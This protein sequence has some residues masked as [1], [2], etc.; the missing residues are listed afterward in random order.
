MSV[1]D[2]VKQKTDIL[3]VIGQYATLTKAGSNF[4]ALCP[5]HSETR[6]SF[7]VYPEQQSWHC[8][9]ACSTG[10]DVFSFIMKKENMDFAEALRLL[11]E[12]AGVTIPSRAE[13]AVGQDRR[14]RLYKVNKSAADY[15]HNLLLNDRA[16]ENARRYSAYRGFSAR[17]IADFHL[18]YGP[19]N[20][21]SLKQHLTEQGY[22]QDELLE[23]G[24]IVKSDG[25][26]THD[27]F[28]NRL[29]FPISDNRE[30]VIGFGAR[31]LDD[32]M[33]KYLNSPQTPVFDKSGTLYAI[34]R[35]TAAI[36]EQNRVVIVEGYMDVIT[37]HQNGF[38]NVVAAMGTAITERQLLILK[39]LSEN[40]VLALDADSAGESAML[41][42]VGYENA[43]NTEVKVVVLPSGKDPDDVIKEDTGTW[44]RLLGEAL[45]VIDYTLNMI[46]ARLDM[47]TARSKSRAVEQLMPIIAE[48]KD[49]TRQDHYLTRLSRLTG[50]GY[51]SLEITLRNLVMAQ[52]SGRP[53]SRE[54]NIQISRPLHSSRL[55]ED[56]LSL[57]LNHPEL[58]EKSDNLVPEYF[59]SQEN[60]EIFLAWRQTDDMP[61]LKDKLDSIIREYFE[62]L[63]AKNLP[64]MDIERRYDDYTSRLKE[65]FF[66]NIEA[67]RAEK[68]ALEAESHGTGT[69][70]AKL[71]AEG[72]EPANQL[73]EI[74]HSRARRGQI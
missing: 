13:P 60:R 74:H 28:R 45:P 34:D 58:K 56:C 24:L 16:A 21:D 20:W 46:T 62:T 14:D 61:S 40:M 7:M 49:S 48:I 69:D 51:R 25:G 6:P 67:R 12:R 52:K 32:S 26:K 11:A 9:G 53:V 59:Q 10:G 35:A 17:T 65:R 1:I 31:A 73:R 66:R 29:I 64:R 55:E 42:C 71:A 57:L 38:T 5:F 36:R 18:G 4:R 23:A 33:P 15:F 68:F 22:S 37:A 54:K 41:R 72:M 8:F 27:R 3:E 39:R 43:L 63:T 30:R 19:N 2:E 47:T 70:L 44:Q 50:T